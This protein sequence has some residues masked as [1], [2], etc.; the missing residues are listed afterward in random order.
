VTAISSGRLGDRQAAVAAFAVYAVVAVAWTWPLSARP[1]RL[2]IDNPDVFGNT[3][4]MAWVAHQAWRDPFHL[5][6]ANL[7]H[8]APHA[9]IY[10]ESLFPEALQGAVVRL[11]GGGPLLAYNT[12]FLLTFPLGGLGVYLLARELWGSPWGA[13]LAGLAYS[14]CA[15]RF[16]HAVH[17]QTLS[18]QWFPFAFLF[19][20]RAARTGSGRDLL[21]L[22]VFSI[23]Q[24]LSSGYYAIALGAGTA[25]ALAADRQTLRRYG[26]ARRVA[27]SMAAAAGVVV[28]VS[29]PYRALRDE[30]VSRSRQEMVHWS[31]RWSSYLD[32]GDY[33][34]LPHL[35]W[36]HERFASRPLY[37]GTAIAALAAIALFRR[38]PRA[39]LAMPLLL[40]AVGVALSLGPEVQLGPWRLPGPYDAL[41][42][43]PPV[44]LLRTPERLGVLAM[45]GVSLLGAAGWAPLAAGR[46]GEAAAGVAV[47]ALM[48]AESFPFGLAHQIRPAPE[49]PAGARWLASAP[50]GVVLELP[51]DHET[52][53]RGALYL[54]WSTLH[55]QPMV[56]G[57]ASFE[58]RGPFELGVIGHRWPSAYTAKVF[59]DAG[60]RYVFV[61]LDAVSEGQRRRL[62]QEPLPEGTRVVF[63]SGWERI[64]E[65]LSGP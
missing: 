35:R 58:P 60:I 33:A 46:R 3:W 18:M 55:W 27:L 29:L 15:Y 31:A 19:L 52:M 6:D 9:L 65:L 2:T 14:G 25:V 62:L 16:E 41:R 40:L 26:T 21:G 5:F 20:R 30:G 45:L 53:T 42:Q 7:F 64:Y 38:R 48:F 36:L 51:W 49:A 10:G 34:W 12:V 43:V 61:H 22:A 24:A 56:N 57:W 13:F 32:P 54:Y 11:A 44:D 47:A 28:L 39:D 1:A 8:P 23:L 4:A 17:V 50:G 59:R 37:P 63:D